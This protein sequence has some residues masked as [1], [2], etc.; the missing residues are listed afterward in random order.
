MAF[1]GTPKSILVNDLFYRKFFKQR[2][3]P[4]NLDFDS[5]RW[6]GKKKGLGRNLNSNK[7][8]YLYKNKKGLKRFKK[9]AFGKFM[10]ASAKS[11]VKPIVVK[12]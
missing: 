11:L 10:L 9:K 6:F 5:Q 4:Y 7:K 12:I 3:E 2:F 1:Y 8:I